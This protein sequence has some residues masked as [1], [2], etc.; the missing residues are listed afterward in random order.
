MFMYGVLPIV[1]MNM[2]ITSMVL[3]SPAGPQLSVQQPYQITYSFCTKWSTGPLWYSIL[4]VVV[5]I[6]FAFWAATVLAVKAHNT[7]NVN[8][9]FISDS[10]FRWW[11]VVSDSRGRS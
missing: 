6:V 5:V 11:S 7:I 4:L 1:A 2:F 3:V 8:S 10:P 9:F